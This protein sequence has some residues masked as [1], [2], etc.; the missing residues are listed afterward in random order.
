[1]QRN[2]KVFNSLKQYFHLLLKPVE[3]SLY[4]HIWDAPKGS[5]TERKHTVTAIYSLADTA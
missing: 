1:M 2:K 3:C 4:L 5:K